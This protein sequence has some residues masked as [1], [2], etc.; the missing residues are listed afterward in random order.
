MCALDAQ[1][2][3]SEF[4]IATLIESMFQKKTQH[5]RAITRAFE[6]GAVLPN[7]VWY[8]GRTANST[9]NL[10]SHVG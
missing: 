5:T 6:I 7:L 3:F 10:H 9:R 4:T 2:K 1:G 8:T